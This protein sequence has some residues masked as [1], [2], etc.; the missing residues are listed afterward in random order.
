MGRDRACC[1]VMGPLLPVT[2]DR[3]WP[4]GGRYPLLVST[5]SAGHGDVHPAERA[6]RRLVPGLVALGGSVSLVPPPA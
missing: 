2:K 1:G 5:S 4:N 6:V 3:I